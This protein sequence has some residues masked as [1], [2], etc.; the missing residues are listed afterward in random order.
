M[1]R[2]LFAGGGYVDQIGNYSLGRGAVAAAARDRHVRAG[3]GR[4]T[5]WASIVAHTQLLVA[6]GGLAL[7]NG[8][9]TAGGAGEH[10]MAKWLARGEGR[11]AR[12][13]GGQPDA[14]R[15]A[16]LPRRAVDPDPAR[17]PTPR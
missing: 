5:D 15:R 10:T 4:V 17:T 1:Q 13:R 8:Q 6:F 3:D 7:K 12:V 9:V 11:R 16:G 2:F 14:R